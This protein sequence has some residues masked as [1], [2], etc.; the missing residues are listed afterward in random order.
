M[1]LMDLVDNHQTKGQVSSNTDLDGAD[2]HELSLEE[3]T[4]RFAKHIERIRLGTGNSAVEIFWSYIDWSFWM[5][6]WETRALAEQLFTDAD[7]FVPYEK[8]ECKT[9]AFEARDFL[10]DKN[11]G[12]SFG[13]MT[14]LWMRGSIGHNADFLFTLIREKSLERMLS[15][16]LGQFFTPPAITSMIAKIVGPQEPVN[17]EWV[18]DCA[19]GFGGMLLADWRE[20]GGLDKPLGSR[21]Y[22]AG[23][24]SARTARACWLGMVVQQMAGYV[25]NINSLSMERFA[26][27]WFTP[28]MLICMKMNTDGL[29]DHFTEHAVER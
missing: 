27:R 23:E 10:V 21:Y 19:A 1:S 26:P 15:K 9:R 4:R 22:A 12:V 25:D 20:W 7:E 29:A 17:G 14:N 11:L 18:I 28:V 5:T 24:L 16:E 3:C 2:I 13:I 6:M 8:D